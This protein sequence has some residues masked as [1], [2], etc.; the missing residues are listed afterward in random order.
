MYALT[1]FELSNQ[2]L[3]EAERQIAWSPDSVEVNVKRPDDLLL[4]STILWP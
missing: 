3:E 1:V 2:E 4:V